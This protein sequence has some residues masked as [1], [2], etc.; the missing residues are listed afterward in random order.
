MKKLR[1]LVLLLAPMLFLNFTGVQFNNMMD[2]ETVPINQNSTYDKFLVT[3]ERSLTE[4]E[5]LTLRTAFTNVYGVF[6]IETCSNLRPNQE[7][8][9]FHIPIS[10]RPD[11]SDASEIIRPIDY[12]LLELIT[13]SF[14]AGI[15]C[16]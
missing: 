15:D 10:A 3:Y 12:G 11:P 13:F 5:K 16:K 9:V 8:W 14:D 6:D 1:I 2:D 4:Y 7:F